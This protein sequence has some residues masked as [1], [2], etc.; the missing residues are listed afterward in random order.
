MPRDV[1]E[2]IARNLIRN[3]C[4]HARARSIQVVLQADRLQVIDDG[5]GVPAAE[6]PQILARGARG[7]NARG[8]GFGL[9]LSLVQRLC[10]RFGWT[11][12]VDSQPG[13]STRVEWRFG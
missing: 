11:L 4:Q 2:S 8:S 6:L 3:A 5:V 13:V 10:D 9:G 7:T 1:V 12:S